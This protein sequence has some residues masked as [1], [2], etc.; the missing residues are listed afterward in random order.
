MSGRG[1]KMKIRYAGRVLTVRQ[2]ADEL[3]PKLHLDARLIVERIRTGWPADLALT[4]PRMGTQTAELERI[5]VER[6]TQRAAARLAEERLALGPLGRGKQPPAPPREECAPENERVLVHIAEAEAAAARALDLV[7][8]VERIAT[9]Q[10]VL[11]HIHARRAE[12][13]VA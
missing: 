3:D 1:M 2:W 12:S 9:R 6:A 7:R 5:A 4:T 10:A 11:E 13:Q 8:L